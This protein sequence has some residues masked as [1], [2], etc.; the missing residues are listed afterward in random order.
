MENLMKKIAVVVAFVA[1][2][3]MHAAIPGADT[4]FEFY[5]KNNETVRITDFS[6]AGGSIIQKDFAS[7]TLISPSQ[8][9]KI[10]AVRAHIRVE[11][12]NN[13]LIYIQVAVPG[14]GDY[15]YTIKPGHKTVFVT[16]T[17]AKTPSLYPQT[18]PLKG[19][20]GKTETGLPLKNNL[21]AS[22]I[23]QGDFRSTWQ[24]LVK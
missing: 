9:S 12:A 7:N 14:R 2:L 16:F 1:S 3:P 20:L 8:G 19:L 15:K 13:L 4:T 6:V 5:N 10:S 21:S 17:S 11:D 24:K 23:T 18:G 22:D